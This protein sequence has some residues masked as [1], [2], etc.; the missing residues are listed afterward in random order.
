MAGAALQDHRKLTLADGFAGT[1][2]TVFCDTKGGLLRKSNFRRKTWLPLLKAAGLPC[3]RFHDLRHT[4]A[5]L[6]F[7]DDTNPKV[8]QEM[9]G[10]ANIST[11]LNTYSHVMPGM[12]KEA[13]RRFDRILA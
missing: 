7:K 5:T 2:E 12:Q 9:L 6:L 3:I 10:H 1:A 4:A 8:V 13:A 11:T